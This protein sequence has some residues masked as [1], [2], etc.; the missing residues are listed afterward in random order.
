M[1]AWETHGSVA[2]GPG[3]VTQVKRVTGRSRDGR[4]AI[5]QRKYLQT[6]TVRTDSHAI[7]RMPPLTWLQILPRA[8]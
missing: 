1:G 4:T 8:T 5:G 7:G 6:A 2:K 3:Q